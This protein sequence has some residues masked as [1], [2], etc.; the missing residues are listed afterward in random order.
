MRR[1]RVG[2]TQHGG[3][4]ADGVPEGLT[5]AEK[6]DPHVAA[7]GDQLIAKGG[8]MDLLAWSGRTLVP[9]DY[10]GVLRSSAGVRAG[11]AGNDVDRCRF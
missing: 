8:R 6:V 3:G 5:L 4:G 11:Y 2:D 1:L 9:E 10:V 7:L